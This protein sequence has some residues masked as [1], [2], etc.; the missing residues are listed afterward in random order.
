[1]WSHDPMSPTHKLEA[2]ILNKGNVKLRAASDFKEY[3]NLWPFRICTTVMSQEGHVLYVCATCKDPWNWNKGKITKCLN[4]IISAIEC[5]WH[6]DTQSCIFMGS[7]T[8]F[9]T[10]HNTQL[11]Y[12]KPYSLNTHTHTH[13]NKSCIHIFTTL[14]KLPTLIFGPQLR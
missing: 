12:S 1:M 4:N 2:T 14:P 13:T 6:E 7:N 3:T 11:H 10:I 8:V 5:F 9:K